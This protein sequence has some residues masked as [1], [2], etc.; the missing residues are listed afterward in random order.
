MSRHALP[1]GPQARPGKQAEI[2][3]ATGAGRCAIGRRRTDE[4]ASQPQRIERLSIPA[5]P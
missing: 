3:A 4:P 1:A 2:E 5:T